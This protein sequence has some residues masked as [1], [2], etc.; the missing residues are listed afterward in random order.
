MAQEH[1]VGLALS[2]GVSKGEAM[3]AVDID[4]LVAILDFFDVG[5]RVRDVLMG[6]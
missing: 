1:G 6:G 3:V 5:A 4:A 2:K